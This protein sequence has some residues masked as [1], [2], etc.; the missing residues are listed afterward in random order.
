[1]PDD[2]PFKNQDVIEV[3]FNETGNCILA[4]YIGEMNARGYVWLIVPNSISEPARANLSRQSLRNL[5][6]NN[7]P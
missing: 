4:Y 1:M 6:K 2:K 7:L 5:H 3:V